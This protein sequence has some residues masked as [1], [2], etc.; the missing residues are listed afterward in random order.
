VP[1]SAGSSHHSVGDRVF[2]KEQGKSTGEWGGSARP[3]VEL[4][5]YDKKR[6]SK[7]KKEN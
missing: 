4:Q 2:R 3:F 7:E 5:V 1:I 6:S